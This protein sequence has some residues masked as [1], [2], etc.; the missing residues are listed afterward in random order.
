VSE[1][2]KRPG[3]QSRAFQK[4]NRRR[5]VVNAQSRYCVFS[6]WASQNFE[7]IQMTIIAESW[8]W[9][10]GVSSPLQRLALVVLAEF[11]DSKHLVEMPTEAF[12]YYCT[13][14]DNEVEQ[15]LKGLQEDDFISILH[16]SRKTIVVI[17]KVK[18]NDGGEE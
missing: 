6:I 15:T 1:K 18:I 3:L 9:D 7:V 10:A 17:L 8:A 11:A 16:V 13:I 5:S 12:T 14:R 2:A 4:L